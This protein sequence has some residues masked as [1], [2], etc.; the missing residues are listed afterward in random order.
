MTM[1]DSSPWGRWGARGSC[2]QE[3]PPGFGWLLHWERLKPIWSEAWEGK[4]KLFGCCQQR[5][6]CKLPCTRAEL[7]SWSMGRGCF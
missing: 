6:G 7:C 2:R 1:Y 3:L 4:V 5:C